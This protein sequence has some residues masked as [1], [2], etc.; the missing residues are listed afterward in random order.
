MAKRLADCTLACNHQK[1]QR[2]QFFTNLLLFHI[3]WS[4][5]KRHVITGCYRKH[6]HS[7]KWICRTRRGFT[8][9][10]KRLT[11]RAPDFE[12]TQNFG[13]NSSF[14]HFCMQLYLYFLSFNALFVSMPL[15]KYLH[16]RMSAKDEVND[17]AWSRKDRK[18]YVEHALA[19][20]IKYDKITSDFA[21]EKSRRS[22][23]M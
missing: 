23:T 19:R 2:L 20:K 10:L 21:D 7:T 22:P 12:G 15:A 6:L 8:I 3:L 4:L 18:A 9:R 17:D 5:L 1:D 16:R 13:S 14:Q 11:S